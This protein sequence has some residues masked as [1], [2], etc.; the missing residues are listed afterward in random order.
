[1]IVGHIGAG[2]SGIDT[3]D[4]KHS[5]RFAASRSA[6]LS[7]ASF[8]TSATATYFAAIKRGRLGAISPI[9]GTN[10]R[11]NANDTI[12]AFG[13]T[14]TAVFR[15]PSSWLFI[16]VGNGEMRING[17]SYG[18]V[19]TSAITGLRIGF[20]GTNYFDGY[21]ARLGVVDTV[22]SSYSNFG[23]FNTEINEWVTKSQGQV[24]A[25]VDAGGTNS[26]MLDFDD[27]TSLTA[28]GYDK[29]IHG[30]HWTLNNHSLTAGV[31][32]DWVEDVPGN[33]YAVLSPLNNAG[34]RHTVSQGNLAASLA[35]AA[36]DR[37]LHG[38]I[39][40]SS[41]KW[42]F[43]YIP[44]IATSVG[45][46]G[47]ASNTAVTSG[48]G[49]PQANS[50]IY[51]GNGGVR[52]NAS[53]IGT[54]TPYTTNDVIGVAF[55]L[56]ALTVAFYKNSTLITAVTGVTA[57][58][59][60]L[61]SFA[62]YPGDA[63]VVNAGQ[64]PFAHTPPAGFNSLCQA[65]LP[66]LA[67]LNPTDHHTVL[68]LTKS[69]DTN[70]TLPWNATNYD[71][72]FW[73]KRR[74]ASGDWYQIDGLRGYDKI[75]KSN[76]PAAETTDANVLGVSGTTCTLKSAL[77]NGVYVVYAW[78]AGLV[79]ARATNTAG[80]ITSTVS[81]NV[82]AG[83]SIV[84][85]TGTGANATVGHGLGVGPK[86]VIV[87]SLN[88]GGPAA[89][90]W[91]VWHQAFSGLEYAF[92][93]SPSAK[94]SAATV[95]NSTVPTSSVFSLGS[96][97]LGN[98][99]TTY[100]AYCHAE[101]PGYSKFGSYTGNGSADGPFVWCDGN[102]MD[103]LIKRSDAAAPWQIHDSARDPNNVSSRDLYPPYAD[104]E[105][106]GASNAAIDMLANGVK[107]R[108]TVSAGNANGGTYIYA[109]YAKSA[110]KYSNSR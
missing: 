51:F 63:F 103:V 82:D 70:F 31:N 65:N 11:F 59:Y 23:Y 14:T 64:R 9:F 1:M 79:P 39:F 43:E 37:M 71:T 52:K 102:P 60:S 99:A 58:A 93:S 5:L 40:P 96:D 3:G 47:I 100:V 6:S 15:D 69:G 28:L 89:W 101:I 36:D 91:G 24:K 32:Y 68:T 92:L 8:N 75:L 97:S 46:I 13:L 35:T 84:T 56:D 42:Y 66:D 29:S 76:S 12:T 17:V 81:A 86:M 61:A 98:A 106:T 95:W 18:A 7:K 87:K 73:I 54:F 4:I 110:F 10:I 2:S 21:T 41:G 34:T 44:T 88:Q 67:I 72:L 53:L 80:S 22:A 108:N 30:N 109:A 48:G 25:V 85:Y 83:F 74:D 78:K 50:V 16:V 57:E 104:P 105:Y 55:D 107:I 49:I 38:T 19:T 62:N 77:P 90:P 33:S 45:S 94:L 26:F 20:D 27:G